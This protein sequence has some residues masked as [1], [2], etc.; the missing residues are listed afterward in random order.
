MYLV[1][2]DDPGTKA[3]PNANYN[4]NLLTATT[5]AEV[6]PGL[7]TQLDLPLDPISGT[8][9]RGP[10]R[11]RPGPSCC[12]SRRPVR[13]GRAGAAGRS[14]SR[15]TSSARRHGDRRHRRP[16]HADRRPHRP[17]A[18]P[19]PGQR[20]HRELD[21]GSGSTPDTIV[22]SVPAARAARSGPGPK[23]LDASSPR[24]PTAACPASTA[25]RCTCSGTNGTGDHRHYTP[26]VV[27][28]PA[29]P[30]R[31]ERD[32]HA[33]Q[34]AIDAAA[35]RQPAG[36]VARHLQRE[37]ARVEAAEDPGPRPRRHHRR[38]RA[39]GAATRRIRGSTS[40]LGHRRPLLPAERHRLRRRPSRRTR[41]TP[42]IRRTPTHP[43]LRGADITVVA[44][45]THGVRPAAPGRDGMPV[46]RRRG[47]TASA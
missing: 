1:K 3:H 34:N 32:A 36:A 24:T 11:R 22:I 42:A 18:D 41:R 47:S 21:P 30:P 4:P 17:G 43:V 29:P 37:R 26:T 23:Q 2:V 44:K 45:T 15:P 13:A 8:G 28:V 46:R 5:P 7:T 27:N 6:W 35:R 31:R 38:A 20:R 19:D 14:R 10:G 39:A 16:R 40:R 9:V 33:L 12:R 25:S